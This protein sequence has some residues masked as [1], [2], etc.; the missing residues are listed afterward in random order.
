MALTKP[1]KMFLRIFHGTV[2]I[3]GIGR[4]MAEWERDHGSISDCIVYFEN[5]NWK[6]SHLNLHTEA[7]GQ[8]S[9]IYTMLSLFSLCLFRYDLFHFYA[10]SSF[11]PYNLDLPLLKLFGKKILMTYVGSDI[12]LV[13]VEQKRNPYFHHMAVDSHDPKRDRRKKRMM[14]WHN[15]WVDRF[16]TVRNLFAYA[17]TTIPQNKLVRDI[18]VPNTL[19]MSGF[20]PNYCVHPSPIIVHAP[21][22]PLIKGTSVIERVIS[23]LKAEGYSFDFILL[24]QVPHDQA[25]EILKNADIIVDQLYVGGFGNLSMEAMAFGKPVCTYL[26]DD[27]V[28]DYPDLPIVN[29]T[30]DTLKEKLIWL[31][32]NPAERLRL[33]KA[34]RAFAEKHYDREV[35]AR[36]LWQLYQEMLTR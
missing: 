17:A 33:G 20:E 32:E 36:K 8:L 34:G 1:E 21:T 18:W 22:N 3:G 12:R 14:S 4:N 10:G 11:L 23:E 35:V 25:E 26:I 15:R 24:H 7:A 13:E 31:I 9:R 16:I 29:V 5:T 28:R 6:N 19:D 27:V 30:V 2:N